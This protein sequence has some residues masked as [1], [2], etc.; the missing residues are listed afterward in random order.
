MS[1]GLG[2]LWC[3]VLRPVL[4][5]KASS[6]QQRAGKRKRSR[7]SKGGLHVST[8]PAARDG[9]GGKDG[10]GLKRFRMHSGR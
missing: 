5:E 10:K 8:L 2:F 7:R 1:C 3:D 4:V 6:I 9:P